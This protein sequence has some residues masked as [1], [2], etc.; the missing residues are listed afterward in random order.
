MDSLMVLLLTIASLTAWEDDRPERLPGSELSV[1]QAN[2]Q[3][4]YV[5]EARI[6]RLGE[7]RADRS[8]DGGLV[9]PRAF[10]EPS[11]AIKG[12][13]FW[14][15]S[16]QQ[17]SLLLTQNDT[18]PTVGE[19]YVFYIEKM[20]RG[21]EV[22]KI[23]HRDGAIPLRETGSC[24]SLAEAE[25]AALYVI[26][27]KVQDLGKMEWDPQRPP[28]GLIYPRVVIEPSSVIKGADKAAALAIR[29][30][31]LP[32]ARDETSLE[33]GRTYIFGS[34]AESVGE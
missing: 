29:H 28:R 7:R 18:I 30:V 22:I 9:Y 14:D 31:R 25:K 1:V 21:L 10:I 15:E 33:E 2:R 19:L 16:P 13:R 8:R 20:G 12:A 11:K 32:F 3:A 23:T 4:L 17:V 34:S 27:A 6:L 5:V 24:I 26:E